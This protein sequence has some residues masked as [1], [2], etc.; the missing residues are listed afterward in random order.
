MSGLKARLFPT[1]F[2]LLNAFH[3][4]PAR[5]ATEA[6]QGTSPLV[7][8]SLVAAWTVARVREKNIPE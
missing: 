4:S 6:L 5:R 8:E 2:P 3:R 7:R 1:P